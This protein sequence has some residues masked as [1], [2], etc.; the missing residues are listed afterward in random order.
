MTF[1]AAKLKA[2]IE[3][4]KAEKTLALIDKMDRTTL[5]TLLRLDHQGIK[6][7]TSRL[8]R[9]AKRHLKLGLIGEDDLQSLARYYKS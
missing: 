3:D 9:Q 6:H 1:E 4:G 8:K 7:N 2:Q 5:L